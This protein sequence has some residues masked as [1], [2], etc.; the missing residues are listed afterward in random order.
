MTTLTR[1]QFL[2]ASALGV[3]AAPHLAAQARPRR[4][5]SFGL[6]LSFQSYGMRES[7]SEDFPG[8]MKKVAELG[9]SGVEMCS[10]PG[11]QNAGFGPL[12]ALSASEQRRIIEDAG[13]FC[14]SCHFS[15]G[16]ELL[17]DNLP[18]ALE[19]AQGIGLRDLVMSSAAVPREATLDDYK[20]FCE[21]SNVAGEKIAE[22]GF[23]LVYHNHAI[24]PVF[25]DVPLYDHLMASFDPVLVKMQ[26]QLASIADGYDIIEYLAKYPGRYISLHMHDY[27]PNEPSPRPNNPNAMGKIVPIGE[28]VIDWKKLMEKAG[29]A[30]IASYGLIVEIETRPPDDP[31]DG[32]RKSYAFLNG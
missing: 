14:R 22:A 31:L 3:L 27:N 32:L 9:Y 24:G 16:R 28:G 30:G 29:S 15:G 11:Y 7:I 4:V 12:M 21:Q 10:P 17:G 5:E 25:D 8:T 19:Y 23:Q 20:R 6:P 13:L 26:F 1:R 18:Q 2:G